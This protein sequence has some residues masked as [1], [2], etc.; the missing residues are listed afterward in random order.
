MVR[1]PTASSP[2]TPALIGARTDTLLPCAPALCL[3]PTFVPDHRPC[4]LSRPFA[5]VSQPSFKA[6]LQLEPHARLQARFMQPQG[7]REKSEIKNKFDFC[8]KNPLSDKKATSVIGALWHSWQ[9]HSPV[10][11]STDAQSPPRRSGAVV[12]ARATDRNANPAANLVAHS[13]HAAWIR[14]SKERPAPLLHAWPCEHSKRLVPSFPASPPSSPSSSSSSCCST[15]L[16]KNFPF[17]LRVFIHRRTRPSPNT[18]RIPD[19]RLPFA[20]AIRRLHNNAG[21]HPQLL[22]PFASPLC[23][24]GTVGVARPRPQLGSY[25]ACRLVRFIPRFPF[26]PAAAALSRARG[27]HL[28][29]NQPHEIR[30]T[31]FHA[32]L[33]L[34]NQS[35]NSQGCF[36]L[37][38]FARALCLC[39]SCVL[40]SF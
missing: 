16:A 10:R 38:R 15:K 24:Y 7:F 40:F 29:S 17:P 22:P 35:P 14:Q 34:P 32:V 31:S 4:S 11:P 37:I 30:P 39:G 25:R 8:E 6:T 2:Y 12:V 28:R 5:F 27:P 23:S 18:A 26:A 19:G 3:L 36:V 21:A 33:G 13:Q 9:R 1:V 20:L